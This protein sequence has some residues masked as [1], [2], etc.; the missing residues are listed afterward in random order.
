MKYD[1]V[2]FF[3][4]GIKNGGIGELCAARL[5]ENGFSGKYKIHAIDGKFVPC[6][7]VSSAIKSNGLDSESMLKAV[8][9]TDER[10]AET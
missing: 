9:Y 1:E 8:N 6:A 2:H 5:L 4:E 3:E 7:A 10:K